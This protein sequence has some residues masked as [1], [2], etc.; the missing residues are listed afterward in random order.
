MTSPDAA[1]ARGLDLDVVLSSFELRDVWQR[2]SVK[3]AVRLL[4]DDE[5]MATWEGT[6]VAAVAVWLHAARGADPH[7]LLPAEA[8]YRLPRCIRLPQLLSGRV[9][10]A[11][12]AD[13]LHEAVHHCLGPAAATIGPSMVTAAIVLLSELRGASEVR[14]GTKRGR[15]RA[16]DLVSERRRSRCA[17][18]QAAVRLSC[19]LD[20][21]PQ[22][23]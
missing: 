5:C 13:P 14:T 6:V 1:E 18:G 10:W 17:G 9:F 19:E 11:P 21:A 8:A 3:D 23:V 2:L 12:G 20:R 7:V 15:R 22:A 16:C 4:I